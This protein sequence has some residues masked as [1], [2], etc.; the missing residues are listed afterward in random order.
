V[1]ATQRLLISVELL[2]LDLPQSVYPC[3]DLYL[4]EQMVALEEVVGLGLLVGILVPAGE[5]SFMP[6]FL[7]D[8]CSPFYTPAKCRVQFNGP[9]LNIR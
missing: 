9:H 2:A 4:W 1:L 7:W 6:F 8:V 3:S 5:V